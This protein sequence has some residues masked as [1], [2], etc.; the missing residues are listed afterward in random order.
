M[1]AL[2][3]TEQEACLPAESGGALQDDVPLAV[4]VGAF[5]GIVEGARRPVARHTFDAAVLGWPL[6]LLGDRVD[7]GQEVIRV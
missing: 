2:S 6:G 4:A 7:E 3:Q 1:V 5:R